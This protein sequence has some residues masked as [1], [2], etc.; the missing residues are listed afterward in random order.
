M[1]YL[2]T[3]LFSTPS[4]SGAT[5]TTQE[6]FQILLR[7]FNAAHSL[8]LQEEAQLTTLT[9]CIVIPVKVDGQGEEREKGTK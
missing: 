8:I 7:S 9:A 6:V 1:E 2:N 4:K 3:A 5:M